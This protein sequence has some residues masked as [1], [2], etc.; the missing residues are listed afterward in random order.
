[1]E[2]NR[3]IANFGVVKKLFVVVKRLFYPRVVFLLRE[4]K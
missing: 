4:N 1:M 2:N 3:G